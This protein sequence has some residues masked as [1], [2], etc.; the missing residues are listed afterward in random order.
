MTK[1]DARF[2]DGRVNLTLEK[3]ALSLD[4]VSR[5]VFERYQFR[6]GLK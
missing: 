1:V 3:R 4:T 2:V 6:L 5:N